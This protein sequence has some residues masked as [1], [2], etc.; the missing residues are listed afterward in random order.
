M[1]YQ[2]TKA[3]KWI[4]TDQMEEARLKLLRMALESGELERR[5]ETL[6]LHVCVT[7][8]DE[9]VTLTVSNEGGRAPIAFLT[10]Q[11]EAAMRCYDE[12]S[13][14]R[15]LAAVS[16]RL[17][18]LKAIAKEQPII[19]FS[20]AGELARIKRNVIMDQPRIHVQRWDRWGLIMGD[21][22]FEWRLIKTKRADKMTKY[23]DEHQKLPKYF[24]DGSERAGKVK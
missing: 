15:I 4:W 18:Q 11:Q 12:N 19:I 1:L 14:E 2:G 20:M 23:H 13:A 10:H 8:Q 7:E 16:K 9:E 24:T 17:L 22:Q 5:D 3:G 6:P 21:L